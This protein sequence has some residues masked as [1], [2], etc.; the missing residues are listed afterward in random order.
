MFALPASRNGIYLEVSV[1]LFICLLFIL[2][3]CVKHFISCLCQSQ[4]FFS[5]VFVSARLLF[6]VRVC[7][8]HLFV[9]AICDPLIGASIVVC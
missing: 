7:V 5:K 2:S 8:R 6:G 1:R 4:I 9:I 3:A